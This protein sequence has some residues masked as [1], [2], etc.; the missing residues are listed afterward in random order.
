MDADTTRRKNAHWDILEDFKAGNAQVLLGTQMIAKGLDI[1]SVTLVGV[2][3]ADTSLGLPDFRAGERTFQLLTQVSGRAGRGA[4][5][6]KVIVQTYSPDH[7]AIASALRGDDSSFYRTELSFRRE[8]GY[9]PFR[10]LINIVLTS[11][12]EVHA[13]NAATAL[14]ELLRP[15]IKPEDGEILGPAPAPLSR[16]KG[17]YRYHLTLKTPSLDRVARQVEEGLASYEVFRDS[18]S[19]QE[20]IPKEDISLTV[21]VDPVNL[22]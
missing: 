15:A 16:I 11:R 1:P 4:R 12:G 9:P 8:A 3:N 14:C 5:P 20:R 7:Y 13:H 22:L 21:D 2:I 18:Y 10:S 19:R 17:R 6:G